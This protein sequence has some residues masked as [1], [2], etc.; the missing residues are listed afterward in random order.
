MANIDPSG[1]VAPGFEGYL[2]DMMNRAWGLSREQFQPYTGSRFAFETPEGKPGY[3]PLESEAFKGLGAIGSY[4]PTTFNTGLGPV[5]S[6]QDYMNPYLQ[7]VVD[8]QAR[9]ARRQADIG[10]QS[11][12]ARLAQAGAY[13]GSRQAIM[14]AERQRNLGTQIGDIQEKGLMAAYDAAQKQRLAESTLGLEGQRLGEMSRQFGAGQDLRT[15]GEQMKAGTIQ[16]GIEQAPLDFGYQ[17]WSES[18]NFPYKQLTFMR[19]IVSG[20]P[21]NA[22]P[23]NPGTSSFGNMLQ[24]G[25]GGLAFYNLLTGNK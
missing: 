14:E 15:I 10:R 16:R 23:Y 5:G 12:Q 22:Q 13:G 21:I 20:M 19:D 18:Q 4:K 24:G 25:L 8:I 17:Q 11:E 3:S 2:E 9:E 6:V 1:T 7:N